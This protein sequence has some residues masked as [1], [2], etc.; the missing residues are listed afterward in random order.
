MAN[1]RA[2]SK[3][4]DV[5]NHVVGGQH[6]VDQHEGSQNAG[7]GCLLWSVHN[8]SMGDASGM[9]PQEVCVLREHDATFSGSLFQML[10]VIDGL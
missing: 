3:K 2:G 9:Q 8:A 4:F 10:F 5:T 6:I 7:N 1:S